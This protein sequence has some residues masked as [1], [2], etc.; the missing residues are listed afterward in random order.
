[1]TS[2]GGDTRV[3]VGV[4]FVTLHLLVYSCGD[5][6]AESQHK[7]RRGF[8]ET[9]KKRKHISALLV[10]PATAVPEE[11]F[12]KMLLFSGPDIARRL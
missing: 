4:C 12:E 8:M 3:C 7:H 5:V 2:S 1:M 9:F 11:I 6:R 10:P